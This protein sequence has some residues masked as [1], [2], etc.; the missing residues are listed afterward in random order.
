MEFVQK[1]LDIRDKHTLIIEK[2]F[3][4]DKQFHRVLREAFE[5]FLNVDARC[6]TFLSLYVDEMMKHGFKGVSE[7][8]VD[9]VLDKVVI[10]FR[11]LRDKD[12]FE[13]VYKTHL[14]KRLLDGRSLSD[15]VERSMLTKLKVTCRRCNECCVPWFRAIEFV[16]VYLQR[17]AGGV[18]LSVHI[19]DGRDVH[20]LGKLQKHAQSLSKGGDFGCVVSPILRREWFVCCGAGGR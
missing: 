19:K 6:S 3:S 17:C 10:I 4:N 9:A 2:S 15:D 1:L 12:V 20:G 18:R 7:A 11:Y 8:D 13:A 16:A 14:Q 5:T